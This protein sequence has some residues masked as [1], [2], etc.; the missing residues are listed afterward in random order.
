MT[1][2]MKS[3]TVAHLGVASDLGGAT[4]VVLNE[5]TGWLEPFVTLDYARWDDM[6][7]P[8]QITVTIEPGDLLNPEETR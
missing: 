1:T 3:R 4:F 8:G 2:L 6:G 5:D 7:R